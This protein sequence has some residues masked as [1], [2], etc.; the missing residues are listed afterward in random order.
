MLST[1]HLFLEI[2]PF[3][4]KQPGAKFLYSSKFNQ[5]SVEAYYGQQRSK[6]GRNDNPTVQ[7]RHSQGWAW[8]C[9]CP[10]INIFS[11]RPIVLGNTRLN[12]LHKHCIVCTQYTTVVQIY[13]WQCSLEYSLAAAG[14]FQ[15]TFTAHAE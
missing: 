11:C 15:S 6:G 7:H 14:E 13:L 10:T 8:V 5:D 1:V 3:L 2:A 4:L 12:T 9:I